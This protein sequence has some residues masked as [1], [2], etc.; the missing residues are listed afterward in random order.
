[1]V[2]LALTNEQDNAI[3]DKHHQRNEAKSIVDFEFT[4]DHLH[5]VEAETHGNQ[6]QQVQHDK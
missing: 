6:S 2:C 5:G 3:R 1:M 4:V